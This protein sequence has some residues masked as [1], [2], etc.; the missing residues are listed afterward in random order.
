MTQHS[1]GPDSDST[2]LLH[3]PLRSIYLRRSVCFFSDLSRSIGQVGKCDDS[4]TNILS[5]K[6]NKPE[7]CG[8]IYALK[9][10]M[11]PITEREWRL[12]LLLLAC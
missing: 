1:Q 10:T 12:V 7:P 9:K 6:S 4:D 5:Y 11:L 8:Y 3:V 2:Y